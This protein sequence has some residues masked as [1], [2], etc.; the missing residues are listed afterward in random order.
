MDDIKYTQDKRMKGLFSIE[1]NLSIFFEFWTIWLYIFVISNCIFY[2]NL[3][4]K[5]HDKVYFLKMQA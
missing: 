3:A 5:A 1:W 4:F 2:L